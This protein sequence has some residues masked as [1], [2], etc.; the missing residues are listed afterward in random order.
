MCYSF[1]HSEPRAELLGGGGDECE[2]RGGRAGVRQ[3]RRFLPFGFAPVIAQ[4]DLTGPPVCLGQTARVPASAGRR[5]SQSDRR[6]PADGGSAD[7]FRRPSED[8]LLIGI[9]DDPASPTLPDDTR[10][11]HHEKN[12]SFFGSYGAALQGARLLAMCIVRSSQPKSCRPRSRLMEQ[13]EA[14]SAWSMKRRAMR[15]RHG[16][17]IAFLALGTE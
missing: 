1:A 13:A 12:W 10:V 16:L 4:V 9:R 7:G 6:R 3:P 8:D 15:Y 11:S 2:P 14:D 5:G 17:L